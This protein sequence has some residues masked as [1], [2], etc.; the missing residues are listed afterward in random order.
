MCIWRSCRSSSKAGSGRRIVGRVT[1]PND[2]ILVLDVGGTTLTAAVVV[3]DAVVRDP[4]RDSSH[5]SADA[6]TI[7]GHFAAALDRARAG[8]PVGSAVVAMPAPFDYDRGVSLMEHKFASLRGVDVGAVLSS[9]T[10][11]RVA[12]I[13][14]AQAAALG[15]WIELGRPMAPVAMI[16]LGTGV[17]SGLI[18]G[19]RPSGHNEL[20]SAPYLD[21]IVED[22][23]SSRALRRTFAQ[24]TG[25]AVSVADVAALA[26]GGDASAT[27]DFAIYGTH[28]GTAVAGYFADVDLESIAVSGGL[29]GAWHLIEPAASAAYRSSGGRGQ[30]VPSHLEFPALLGGAE[31][32]RRSIDSSA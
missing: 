2:P 4:A 18:V 30:L 13:N 26:D 28:L 23:V 29:T 12:F 32:G 10:G 25:R 15:G 7:V 9:V 17:G 22:R 11:L 1:E 19:G 16:T 24:R 14:D 21:G 6:D 8:W 5:A 3:G 27:D 20:W 31:F